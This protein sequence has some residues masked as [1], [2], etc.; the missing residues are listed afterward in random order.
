MKVEQQVEVKRVLDV[1]SIQEQSG[2]LLGVASFEQPARHWLKTGNPHLNKALG[3]RKYGI[4]FGRLIEL[5]G[6]EHGGKTVLSLILASMGQKQGAAVGYVDLEESRDEAWATKMGLDYSQVV[7]LFPKFVKGKLKLVKGKIKFIGK[8]KRQES[9][10]LIFEKMKESIKLAAEQGFEKQIWI[11]DS[12]AFVMTE[13][14]LEAS[15]VGQ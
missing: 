3:S 10:E 8:E 1:A 7:E 4:P 2:K 13:A 5:R 6:E 15:F 14:D 11:I 12:I 9:A